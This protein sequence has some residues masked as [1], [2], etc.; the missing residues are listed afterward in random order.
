MNRWLNKE[1]LVARKTRCGQRE[2]GY[3]LF[4]KIEKQLE[5]LKRRIAQHTSQLDA[6]CR[7]ATAE[8]EHICRG[9]R[10]RNALHRDFFYIEDID[11]NGTAV[12]V[13]IGA[14]ERIGAPLK[15]SIVEQEFL[16]A[17]V[18]KEIARRAVH[19]RFDNDGAAEQSERYG[20][21]FGRYWSQIAGCQWGMAEQGKAKQGDGYSFHGMNF[22]K[23]EV[24]PEDGWPTP[25][26]SC[27]ENADI[28]CHFAQTNISRHLTF[29]S[30]DQ[31][32]LAQW[33]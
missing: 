25:D 28:P 17:G 26:N 32:N 9:G 6:Y 19:G 13:V 18:E 8:V 31:N 16:R 24:E 10:Q 21:A 2:Q 1:R 3:L 7:F 11:R 33:E 22:L 12:E 14:N 27:L 5:I 23:V 4:L 20:I 15:I 29:V 30:A